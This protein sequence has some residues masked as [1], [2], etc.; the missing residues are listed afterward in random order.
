MT[1]AGAIDERLPAFDAMADARSV[2]RSVLG[3]ADSE[4][5]DYLIEL[6]SMDDAEVDDLVE[7]LA[8]HQVTE[9]SEESLREALLLLLIYGPI[10]TV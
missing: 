1:A 6:G 5:L 3:D 4:V 8:A 7:M 2:L 9:A 10:T